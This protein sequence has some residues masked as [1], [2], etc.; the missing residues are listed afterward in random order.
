MLEVR[1][2]QF[3]YGSRDVLK[4]VSFLVSQGEVCSIVGSSG[5]GKTTLLKLL[6]QVMLPGSG[7]IMFDG[8]TNAMSSPIKYRRQIG[9]LPEKVALYEDM[10]PREY[11]KYRAVLKGENSN[12]IRYRVEEAVDKCLIKDVMR[13]PIRKLSMGLKKRVQLADALLLRPRVLLLDDFL[14]GIDRSMTHCIG[15]IL[16]N[17][18]LSSS[19]VVTGHALEEMVKWTTR[20]LILKDGMIAAEIPKTGNDDQLICAKIDQMLCGGRK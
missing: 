17:V 6:A 20:F 13:T 18:S 19:V 14:S 2:L 1:N 7:T 11:L 16:K 8:H 5:A 15:E 9:Y 10:T 3:A 4:N 12:R